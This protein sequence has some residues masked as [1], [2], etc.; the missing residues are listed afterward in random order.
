[1]KLTTKN[2]L[3]MDTL[4]QTNFAD[5]KVDDDNRRVWLSRLTKADGEPFDN[6]VYIEQYSYGKWKVTGFY[7][8]DD[9]DTVIEI[10][11]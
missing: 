10:L 2:L 4:V 3:D 7:S 5:L 9:P 6:T 1:M 11:T 8:G